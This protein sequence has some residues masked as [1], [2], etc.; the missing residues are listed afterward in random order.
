MNASI[1]ISATGKVFGI[2]L[3]PQGHEA[4]SHNWRTDRGNVYAIESFAAPQ[5]AEGGATPPSSSSTASTW[6]MGSLYS[7]FGITPG[8]RPVSD[9][10]DHF[11]PSKTNCLDKQLLVCC[12]T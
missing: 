7:I 4:I 12:H 1:T 10:N 6:P 9:I 5:D 11:W 8:K 2:R 3:R